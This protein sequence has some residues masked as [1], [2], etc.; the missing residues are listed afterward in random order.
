MS[1]ERELM[2][3]KNQVL[4]KYLDGHTAEQISERLEIDLDY[5]KLVIKNYNKGV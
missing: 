3:L 4:E 1:K 5:V 2:R